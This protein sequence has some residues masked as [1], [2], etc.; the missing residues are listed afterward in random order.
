MGL[1]DGKVALIFGVAN[2]NSIAWGI[3]RRLH[4]EGA[5]IGLSYAGEIMEKR[6]FPL[7]QEIGCDFVE[8]CDV[9]SDEQ[10]DTLFAKAKERFGKIDTLVHCVAFANREDLGG[11]FVDISREGFKMALDI[12]AYSLVA[13]AKR[14]AP[15]MTDGGSIMSLTYYAAEKVMPKYHVMAVAKAAL[16]TIT[17]YLANDLGPQGIRVNAISAGPIKTLAAAGV[18][19]FRLMLKYS[20]KAAPLRRLVSQEE[21][22]DTALYLA[23]DLSRSV[24]G[25]VIHVDAGF[26]ILGLTAT[27]DELGGLVE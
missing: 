4:E 16:E 10:L 6:V 15:L 26:N 22:G 11:R 3:T 23:S 5:T 13:M 7:A 17:R 19:G 14:A 9:T 24:T 27:E 25:E 20:E 8:P 1:M 18:P 21:V 2:K 12:S